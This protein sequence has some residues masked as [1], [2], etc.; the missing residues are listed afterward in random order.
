MKLN[1]GAS[2]RQYR[3]RGIVHN[4]II[5][6]NLNKIYTGLKCFVVY[7]KYFI[8]WLYLAF[9]LLITLLL[10]I[11]PI[12]GMFFY[13]YKPYYVSLTDVYFLVIHLV[14][15]ISMATYKKIS[16][17]KCKKNF[18]SFIVHT[19]IIFCKFL[20]LGKL[21]IPFAIVIIATIVAGLLQQDYSI[22]MSDMDKIQYELFT[23]SLATIYLW[24]ESLKILCKPIVPAT[25]R[26]YCSY[27]SRKLNFSNT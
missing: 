6:S 19:P 21:V 1:K 4:K 24:Y 18:K 22:S 25:R 8:F 13:C 10:I 11:Y 2:S 23:W 17:D 27:C 9:S 15:Q 16:F 5:M 26:I 14:C 3:K 12:G 20:I 7:L